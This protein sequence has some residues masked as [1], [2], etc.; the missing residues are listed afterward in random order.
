MSSFQAFM[1]I[2]I[3]QRCLPSVWTLPIW[4]IIKNLFSFS[5]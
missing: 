5:G 1:N 3:A 2:H 4:V